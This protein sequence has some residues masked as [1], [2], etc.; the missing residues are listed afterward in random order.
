MKR[1]KKILFFFCIV[2]VF[3]LAGAY[4]FKPVATDSRIKT[5]V[6]DENEVFQLAV[7]YGYQSNIELAKG[8]EVETISMGN[9][10]S[11][12]ITPVDRRIFI[13]P[14]EP[15][16]KTNMTLITNKRTYQFEIVSR[17]PEESVDEHL[18][19][20]VRFF[21]P[22]IGF[23]QPVPR[24]SSSQFAP[25]APV[26]VMPPM[27]PVSAAPVSQP[28]VV[29]QELS[30]AAMKYNFDYTLVGPERLAPV[31]VFDDGRMTYF[32]FSNNN[33][34][35]PQIFVSGSN[36]DERVNFTRKGDYILVDRVVSQFTL[37]MGGDVVCVFNE[38]KKKQ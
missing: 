26:A 36:T 6:Y 34:N 22:E 31:K 12:Q 25:Q 15:E 10:Y 24:V 3:P 9:Y 28:S 17:Y 5:L 30:R 38:Q 16:A 8:E 35:V 1:C 21:Y 13:K 11:F 37:R 14:L 32:E 7:H 20:V 19:Y 27:S 33:A 23:N 18:V 4:A 2:V 29:A